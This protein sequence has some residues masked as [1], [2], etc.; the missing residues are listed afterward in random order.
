MSNSGMD[1]AP[2]TLTHPILSYLSPVEQHIEIMQSQK[3]LQDTL[4]GKA[5][6]VFAYPNGGT[7]DYNTETIS[8]L[9]NAGFTASLTTQPGT[10]GRHSPAF[11]LPRYTLDGTNDMYRFRLTITGAR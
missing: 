7:N 8:I 10:V 11:E 3:T 1:F 5:L 4:P 6:S 9:Q 2:H